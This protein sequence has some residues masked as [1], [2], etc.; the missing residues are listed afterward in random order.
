[1]K[2]LTLFLLS[3][4]LVLISF[5]SFSEDKEIDS[6][7]WLAVH[8]FTVSEQL[9]QKGVNGWKLAAQ[10]E[11][12]LA[13]KGMYRIVTRAKIAKV[14]KEKNISS[15]SNIDASAMGGMIGADYIITGAITN[16]GNK[17]TLS[18]KLIDVKHEAGEIEKSYDLSVSGDT[19]DESLK[20]LPGL[21]DEMAISMTTTPGELFDRS[22][23]YLDQH[24]YTKAAKDFK[25]LKKQL[26]MEKIRELVVANKD[27]P[28]TNDPT[29][30]T[31]GKLLDYAL[32]MMDK[33]K[34]YEAV[35]AFNKIRTF[36]N[37]KDITEI[38]SLITEAEQEGLKQK[39]DI[40]KSIASAVD[41]LRAA[42]DRNSSREPAQLL[43]EASGMLESILYNPKFVLTPDDKNQIETLLKN[44]K[45]SRKGMY[46]GPAIGKEFLIPD[47]N[48]ALMPIPK[49]TFVMGSES[50]SPED[51]EADNP[52]HTVTISRPFW[53]GKY[54]VTIGEY[55]FFL[56][57]IR[58]NTSLSDDVDKNIKW[59]SDFTPIEKNYTM[60]RGM[61]V[62]WGDKNQPM[63][64]VN[65][66]AAS[67]FCRWLTLRERDAKR[68][69]KGYVFR[70]P[71]EAE[72][73]YVCRAGTTSDYHTPEGAGEY[74]LDEYAWHGGT[75]TEK[76]AVA[77]KKKPNPWGLHDM[78]GNVW[79][80]CYDWYDGTY[81]HDDVT[82]PIGP[83]SSSENL[84]VARGGSFVSDVGDLKSNVRY[85][86][87]YKSA[88]KNVGF[89][90]VLAPE[91]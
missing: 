82:D 71:T 45:D 47:I 11:G 52:A 85:S 9:E 48:I 46:A 14:L 54:E 70:L 29:L 33:E 77:G 35:A 22:L 68:L 60:K 39:A 58:S 42:K 32:E 6:R 75:S 72:W 55:L 34:T 28:P 21:Y 56:S 69:P 57:D 1:M 44:I 20:K 16:N 13:Q 12:A 27:V 5:D 63:V 90:I 7:P 41:L 4:A 84:K 64:G 81:L 25:E 24:N 51:D 8:D 23:R 18:A 76:T 67:E 66:I 15:S 17:I 79:E 91:I 80:W 74:A 73:E 65:S 37:V 83:G 89:R 88:K 2:K 53:M 78:H 43:D 40:E 86:V 19:L 38:D 10:L 50:V 3:F 26:P 87:P 62:T 36:K 31:P 30:V 61:G 59:S 49:G